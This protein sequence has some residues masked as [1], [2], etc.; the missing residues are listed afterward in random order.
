MG[1]IFN[2]PPGW[3]VPYGFEP[4]PDWKP[5]PDW[6]PAPPNWPLWIGGN[7]PRRAGQARQESAG[8]SGQDATALGYQGHLYGY[9]SQGN[10]FQAL[11]DGLSDPNQRRPAS[12][13]SG[14]MKRLAVGLASAIAVIIILAIIGAAVGSTKHGERRTPYGKLGGHHGQV[15]FSTLHTGA[16]LQYPVRGQMISLRPAY[17]TPASCLAPHNAQ[18]FGHFRAREKGS[19]PGSTVLLREARRGCDRVTSRLVQSKITKQMRLVVLYPRQAMW[20][21]RHRALSCAV[22]SL[23]RKVRRSLLEAHTAG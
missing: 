19:Y 20:V 2:P 4:P 17:V 7:A 11:G 12:R 10:G 15:L 22:I 3:P 5:E 1:A 16:C 14:G 9:A 23:G 21:T 13:R 18:I 8:P 6:P